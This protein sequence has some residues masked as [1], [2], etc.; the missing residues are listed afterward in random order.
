MFAAHPDWAFQIPGRHRQIGRNQ[1]VL[2]LSRQ[3]VR[4]YV[5]NSIANVLSR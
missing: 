3:D 2:D 1:M 4:D 5:Y